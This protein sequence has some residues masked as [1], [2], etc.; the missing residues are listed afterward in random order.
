[1][2]KYR[3]VRRDV[4]HLGKVYS[5]GETFEADLPRGEAW[6]RAGILELVDVEDAPVKKQRRRRRKTVVETSSEE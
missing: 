6:I 1:M 3:V 5:V 2:S 4:K